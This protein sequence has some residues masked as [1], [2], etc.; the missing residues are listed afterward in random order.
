MA[1]KNPLES[2]APSPE[3]KAGMNVFAKVEGKKAGPFYLVQIENGTATL[4][5]AELFEVP[6]SDLTASSN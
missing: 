5:G 1:E 4:Q 2:K 3:I 6:V